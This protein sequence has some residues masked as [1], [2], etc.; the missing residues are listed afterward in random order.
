MFSFPFFLDQLFG[1]F[2]KRLSKVSSKRAA[3]MNALCLSNQTRFILGMTCLESQNVSYRNDTMNIKR[4]YDSKSINAT[5]PIRTIVDQLKNHS[6]AISSLNKLHTFCEVPRRNATTIRVHYIKRR[7]E[8]VSRLVRV[9]NFCNR[10]RNSNALIREYITT[11]QEAREN[12]SNY[13]PYASLLVKNIAC[14]IARASKPYNKVTWK[15]LFSE[16]LAWLSVVNN[17]PTNEVDPFARQLDEL[18]TVLTVQDFKRQTK[19]APKN[20]TVIRKVTSGNNTVVISNNLSGCENGTNGTVAFG[21][22]TQS[23]VSKNESVTCLVKVTIGVDDGE[24]G[25]GSGTIT[26]DLLKGGTT[27]R[28]NVSGLGNCINLTFPLAKVANFT[29]PGHVSSDCVDKKLNFPKCIWS[30]NLTNGWNEDQTCCVGNYTN[31][32]V[33][34]VWYVLLGGWIA[35]FE[36]KLLTGVPDRA[37]ICQTRKQRCSR[38]SPKLFA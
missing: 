13:V 30:N 22:G 2:D 28:I 38:F 20:K 17:A 34:C 7:L 11:L 33:L 27:D 19:N 36:W 31:T 32:S 24:G 25:I 23:A 4:L 29:S 35:L 6:K 37:R 8:L 21:S 15:L 5:T 12:K 3:N 9:T 16:I 26:V 1:P 10:S 18:V 14:L